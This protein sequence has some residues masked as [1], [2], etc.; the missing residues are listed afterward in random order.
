MTIVD[1]ATRCILGWKLAWER[2]KDSLQTLVDEAP[3]AKFYD[4]DGF[5]AY[6][7]P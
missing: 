2:T 1:R 6:S 7:L 5:E 4:S 3:Q